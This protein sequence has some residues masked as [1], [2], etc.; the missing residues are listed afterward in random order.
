MSVNG[1]VAVVSDSTAYLPEDLLIGTDIDIVPV[2]VIVAGRAMDETSDA[3][4]TQ[5]VSE[6]LRAWQ[7]VTTSRPTPER[8]RQAFAKAAVDGAT[9]IV[10]ATLSAKM[11]ATFESAWIA[12]R[13]VDLEVRVVDSQTVAMG[14]GFAVLAGER[15]AR[16]GASIDEVESLM[17]R[18]A[19]AATAMFY[20]NTLEYLRRSGRVSAARAAVGQALKVKPLLAVRGGEVVP[21]EKVRTSSKAI[22]R[23][24]ELAVAAVHGPVEIAVQHLDAKERAADLAGELHRQL[25]GTTIVQCPIGAVVAAH[26]GPGIV[27]VVVSPLMERG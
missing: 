12:A 1:R 23:M 17:R 21:L 24:A 2:Q 11:S 26:T 3:I 10:C 5:R 9:G 22:A 25:P 7:P 6:A 19:H 13:E 15:T 16:E 4:S 14:L 18:K 8:F 20:V 27:A